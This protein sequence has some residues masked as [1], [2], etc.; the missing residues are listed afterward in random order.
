MNHFISTVPKAL[1]AIVVL[2][3][4]FAFFVASDP[5]KTAC[6]AQIELFQ[7]AQK[8]FIF[9]RGGGKLPSMGKELF[10]ICQNDNSP[11]ACF[12]FFQRLK[13]FSLDLSNI[14]TQ[15]SDV[16]IADKA[17]SAWVFRSMKLMLQIGWGDRGPAS[18][19]PGRAW[20]DESDLAL[21]C[22]LK[23]NALR[24]YGSEAVSAWRDATLSRLPAAADV[25]TEQTYAKSLFGVSCQAYL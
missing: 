21:F 18:T 5:P 22:S 3:L 9:A 13:K 19:S 20:F 24:L 7:K 12:E 16:A 8:D 14:P 4:G 10:D 6:D 17:T 15:C 1:V 25:P 2:C 23:K 11:G